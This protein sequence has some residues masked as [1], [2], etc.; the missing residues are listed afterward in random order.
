MAGRPFGDTRVGQRVIGSKVDTRGYNVPEG[1]KDSGPGADET[2]DLGPKKVALLVVL[3]PDEKLDLEKTECNRHTY[4]RM[5]KKTEELVEV[6]KDVSPEQLEDIMGLNKKMA[7]SHLDRF[8]KFGKLPPKQACLIFGGQGLKAASFSEAEATKAETHLRIVSGLYGVL[9]PYDDVKPVRDL[10]MDAQLKTKNSESVLEFW[11]EHITSQLGK[12]A[13]ELGR[14]MPAETGGKCLLIGS[15]SEDYWKCMQHRALPKEVTP[16]HCDFVG[17]NRENTSK[18]RSALARY[19]IKKK[20]ANLNELEEFDDD[21]WK[22]DRTKSCSTSMAWNWVGEV[23]GAAK[24]KKEDKKKKHK[25][26]ADRSASPASAPD[27]EVK[28]KAGVYAGSDSEAEATIRPGVIADTDSEAEAEER[29]RRD[30]KKEKAGRERPRSRSRRR[31]PPPRRS[32]SRSR[33]GRDGGGPARRPRA[34]KRQ[35]NDSR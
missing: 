26:K 16:V 8:Q 19:V 23:T 29:R 30:K 35:R 18:G 28:V 32:R 7:T 11:G 5:F 4:I 24:Q 2:G 31:E 20:V 27:N 3:Q 21:D 33:G 14:K 17:A 15:M 1:W 12:D 9:R 6:L 25:K 34:E 10:P 13:L 22:I